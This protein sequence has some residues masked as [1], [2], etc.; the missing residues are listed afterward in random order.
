MSE[1]VACD[2]FERKLF[3]CECDQAE[4]GTVDWVAL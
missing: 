3:V 2:W 4:I 1:Y